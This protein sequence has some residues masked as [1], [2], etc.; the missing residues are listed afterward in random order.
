MV[1]ENSI[2]MM[3]MLGRPYLHDVLKFFNHLEAGFS[4]LEEVSHEAKKAKRKV[5]LLSAFFT[6][7]DT[8]ASTER[9][10]LYRDWSNNQ[11]LLVSY[12][13]Q[14]NSSPLT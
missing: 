5:S 7:S 3:H 14:R 10:L 11:Q 13:D 12:P 8:S 6:S 9:W 2:E 1:H 4:L